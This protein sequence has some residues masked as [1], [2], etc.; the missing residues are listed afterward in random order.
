MRLETEIAAW[1]L[2]QS[3]VTMKEIARMTGSAPSEVEQL[4]VNVLSGQ[5]AEPSIMDGFKPR[6]RG[7]GKC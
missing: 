6:E 4:I 1:S 5:R 3:G 7:D 2:Y